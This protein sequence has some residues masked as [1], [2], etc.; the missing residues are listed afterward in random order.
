[1]KAAQY[2]Q[3]WAYANNVNLLAAN[4]NANVGLFAHYS[5]SGI[6]TGRMA[7]LDIFV[8]KTASTKILIANVP[9]DSPSPSD[10]NDVEAFEIANEEI[11]FT[12]DTTKMEKSSSWFERSGSAN[13]TYDRQ[14]IQENLTLYTIEFLDLTKP[15]SYNETVCSGDL[16]CHYEIDADDIGAQDGMVSDDFKCSF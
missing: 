12:K 7:A 11:K 15:R 1:M 14:V 5:G 10:D 9:I 4:A 3:S 13:G 2:Q 8:T 6:Y 16:R